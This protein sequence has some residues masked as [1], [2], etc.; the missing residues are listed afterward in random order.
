MRASSS[1]AKPVYL[2]R[3]PFRASLCCAIPL[4]VAR[5]SCYIA[6]TVPRNID[7][8][9]RAKTH[10][11]K[12]H[13]RH[14]GGCRKTSRRREPGRN[15]E[16]SPAQDSTAHA[17]IPAPE[18]GGGGASRHRR[19][20][21][22]SEIPPAGGR[23]R[24]RRCDP[25][26]RRNQGR[27]GARDFES[28]RTDSPLSAPAAHGAKAGR[29]QPRISR[30]VS[31]ECDGLPFACGAHASRQNRPVELCDRSGGHLRQTAS[32]PLADRSVMEFESA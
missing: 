25:E 3:K 4:F 20:E 28:G 26:A 11:R 16:G 12:G 31:S 17:A 32:Q 6:Q 10:I 30:F 22:G 23:S 19:G 1:C 18:P 7:R 9:A 24:A 14:S 8:S 29:L 2:A 27:E 21:P 15:R 5:N 13:S